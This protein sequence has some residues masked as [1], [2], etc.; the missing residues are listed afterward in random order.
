MKK[1][2][3]FVVIVVAPLLLMFVSFLS[4]SQQ[5][6]SSEQVLSFTHLTL[7]V[8]STKESYVRLEPIQ[9]NLSL[10]NRTLHPIFG[11]KAIG[12]ADQHLELFV[13]NAVGER[14][15]INN[16]SSI[17]KLLAVDNVRI[18][19]G[20]REERGELIT[21]DLNEFFPEPGTYQIQAVLHSVGWGEE[22]ES[23]TATVRILEP[24]G[25]D[26][27]A[28]DF[29]RNSPRSSYFFDGIGLA[30]SEREFREMNEFMS[31]FGESAYGDYAVFQLAMVHFGRRDY[32]RAI[33]YF[34]Q[35]ASRTNF[36]FADRVSSYLDRARA[37]LREPI[38]P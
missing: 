10:S 1:Q 17:A 25:L 2:I 4:V 29:I 31:R 7:E 3:N 21:L 9:I 28:F 35:L 5:R 19:P 26:Y 37:A 32:Q 8:A 13:T 33:Q 27:T 34:N 38:I 16:L 12:F 18:A 6:G 23:N 15:E 11:H 20:V 14:R 24:Q 30:E 36:V 22:I